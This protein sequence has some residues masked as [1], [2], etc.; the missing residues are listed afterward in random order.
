MTR[1]EQGIRKAE[2]ELKEIQRRHRH[3]PKEYHLFVDSSCDT[4]IPQSSITGAQIK[5]LVSNLNP[6]YS[7]YE[8]GVGDEP[9][10]LIRIPKE[11]PLKGERHDSILFHRRHLVWHEPRS[12]AIRGSQA[13]THRGRRRVTSAS[14]RF[15]SYLGSERQAP[16]RLVATADHNSIH[17]ATSIPA[18]ETRLLLGRR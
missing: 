3:H 18:R 17:C 10:K 5:S 4:L 12:R 7:L 8:E 14:R 1:G 11:F 9:D 16:R 2:E 13:T 6:T 15:A